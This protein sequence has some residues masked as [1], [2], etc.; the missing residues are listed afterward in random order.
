MINFFRNIFIWW[1]RQTI[2]T[3]LYTLFFGKFRGTDEFGNK[4]YESKLGKRWVIYA[5]EINASRSIS[6]RYCSSTDL[7]SPA[8]SPPVS[9]N[10][11]FFA[12]SS[13]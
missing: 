6:N 12:I 11:N 5:S 4:Y 8:L 13:S 1:N 7:V 2:G 10:A 3:M 9:T